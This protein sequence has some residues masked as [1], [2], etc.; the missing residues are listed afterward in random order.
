MTERRRQKSPSCPRMTAFGGPSSDLWK[1]I[2]LFELLTTWFSKTRKSRG[3]NTSNNNKY[4]ITTRVASPIVDEDAVD[5]VFVVEEEDPPVV[6]TAG[7]RR[8][9]AEVS[10][11]AFIRNGQFS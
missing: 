3:C 5:M 10:V 7:L 2:A 9:P 8:S 1:S 4:Q 11:L 6:E